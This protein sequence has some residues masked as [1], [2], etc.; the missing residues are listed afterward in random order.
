MFDMAEAS[1]T[2][3]NY[4][5]AAKYL[6]LGAFSLSRQNRMLCSS[7]A[8]ALMRVISEGIHKD[9]STSSAEASLATHARVM[10]VLSEALPAGGLTAM[11]TRWI[12]ND[13][14]HTIASVVVLG[15]QLTIPSALEAAVLATG[16]KVHRPPSPESFVLTAQWLR[17]TVQNSFD[18]VVLHI[19][20]SDVICG[21]AFN[22]PGGPPVL[23]VNHTAHTFWTGVAYADLVVNCRASELEASWA[24]LY[25][26]THRYCKIPIPLKDESAPRN[27]DQSRHDLIR[28]LRAHDSSTFLLTVGAR[29][30]YGSTDD[31]D[32]LDVLLKVLSQRPNAYLLVAGFQPDERWKAASGEVGGRIHVLGTRSRLQLLDLYSAIDIYVEGFPFGT[33]TSLLEA[34]AS[35]CAIVL[36]PAACPPPY[37]TDGIAVDGVLR[38]A[39]DADTYVKNLLELIDDA[40]R[41]RDI[42]ARIQASVQR[43]HLGSGWREHLRVAES[44][45]PRSHLVYPLTETL[46]T[47]SFIHNFWSDFSRRFS[48][49]YTEAL[50]HVLIRAVTFGLLPRFSRVARDDLCIKIMRSGGKKRQVVVAAVV[51]NL[52]P[53]SM[54][55]GLRVL[56]LRVATYLAR[57]ELL[58]RTFAT[59]RRILRLEKHIG[60]YDE[61]RQ[62]SGK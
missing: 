1:L 4:E 52:F 59:A 36:P 39:D 34:A 22:V 46:P 56:F 31:L 33:T 14:E 62:F 60:A 54:H 6:H 40:D 25:R 44:R 2:D 43:H 28:E 23:L 18:Y 11:A 8:E 42:S 16:G 45:L 32:F 12:A 19:D 50:E 24:R 27:R 51:C 61:Y 29:F 26:G 58:R 35:G 7:R 5:A 9:L 49:P 47:P 3:G 15:R 38:Q 30:K 41:R 10:H 48:W 17:D 57:P 21:I 55:L 37:A 53:A 20:V 13:S